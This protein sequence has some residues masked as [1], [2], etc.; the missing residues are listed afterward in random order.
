MRCFD[1]DLPLSWAISRALYFLSD[2]VVMI[3]SEPNRAGLLANGRICIRYGQNPSYGIVAEG[4]RW[5]FP[6]NLGK[7][8]QQLPKTRI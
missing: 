6:L 5:W 7:L 2:D 8:I 1:N 4:I 3:R